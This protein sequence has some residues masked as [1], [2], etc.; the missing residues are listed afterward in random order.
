[1]KRSEITGFLADL[2]AEIVARPVLVNLLI[3]GKKMGPG[4]FVLAQKGPGT[5]ICFKLKDE[6]TGW[7][8]DVNA[9]E[10]IQCA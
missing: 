9:V 10:A 5:L 8:L 6:G 7:W 1:M 4:H 3:S 2:E